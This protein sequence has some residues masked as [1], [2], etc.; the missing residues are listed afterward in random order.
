MLHTDV[1]GNRIPTPGTASKRKG[2][3]KGK[4]IKITDA[5]VRRRCVHDYTAGLHPCLELCKF[6]LLCSNIQI[7]RRGMTQ[8][9]VINQLF[10]FCKSILD[11]CST[12]HCKHGRK[13]F[14]CEFLR[15]FNRLHFAD[16]NLGSFRNRNAGKRSNR[17]C[18]L[19]DNTGIQR[20]VDDHRLADL[21]CLFRIEE[22]ASAGCELMANLIIN[23][24]QNNDGLF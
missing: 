4:V 13:L 21:F 18:T 6:I 5:A 17:C 1:L 23:L 19:A 15:E 20:T 7:N 16:Q 22:V 11:V 3:S 10:R 24:I 2:R 14:M 12:V 8:P 9:A